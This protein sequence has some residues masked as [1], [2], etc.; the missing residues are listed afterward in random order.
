MI[1]TFLCFNNVV[2]KS[3]GTFF[4]KKCCKYKKIQ[5]FHRNYPCTHNF[6]V[7][8]QWT[9][10]GSWQSCSISC[11]GGTKKELEANLSK[12]KM[13]DWIVLEIIKNPKIV[14]RPN[15]QVRHLLAESELKKERN[16]SLSISGYQMR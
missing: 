14:V 13:E 2:S 5:Q 1:V 12:L 7:K 16:F 3:E 15:V 8:C 9:S 6:L 11:G 10:W 4:M